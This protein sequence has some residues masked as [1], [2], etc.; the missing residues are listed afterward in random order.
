MNPQPS[1]LISKANKRVNANIISR[2][3]FVIKSVLFSDKFLS[4]RQI[5]L[6]NGIREAIQNRRPK[7]FFRGIK[8]TTHYIKYKYYRK[9]C[10][11]LMEG[12]KR[13][14]EE[15]QVEIM[16]G[17]AVSKVRIET[18]K[19]GGVCTTDQGELA[20]KRMLISKHTKFDDLYIDKPIEFKKNP[21]FKKHFVMHIRG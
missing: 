2:I 4:C 3:G 20:F 12:M 19:E 10:G 18:S 15:S 9:G 8:R 1:F 13:L 17:V 14:L 21:W 7:D 16:Q 6:V 5:Q 11:E